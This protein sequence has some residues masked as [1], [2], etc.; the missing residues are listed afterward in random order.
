VVKRIWAGW[1]MKYILGDKSSNCIFCEKLQAGDDASNYILHRG[2]QVALMLNLF[3]YVNGHLLVVPYDH[4]ADLEQL[5]D[6]TLSE[7]MLTTVKALRLLRTAMN[8]HGFNVGVNL[9]QAAGAG[10]Q[11]HV[12]IH[13]VPRW[14]GD[15]NF[16]PVFGDVRVIPEWLGDT[17]S[18]L[19]VALRGM[20][21]ESS[22][23]R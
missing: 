18:K 1:R 12:H 15:T 23:I 6:E 16:M 4:V 8:P 7:M 5:D 9:G 22:S 21:G 20:A 17:Y 2:E 11:D 10:I 14:Q 3:P 13:V 19:L